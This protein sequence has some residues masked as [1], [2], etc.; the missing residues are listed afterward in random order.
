MSQPGYPG[1]VA[2]PAPSP[3]LSRTDLV[4]SVATLAVTAACGALAALLGV[5]LLAFLDDCPP[6]TCHVESAVTA[7]GAGLLVAF[8][9]GVIGLVA[10]VIQLVRR[11]PAWPFAVATLVLVLIAL[12]GGVVAYSAAVGA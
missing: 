9:I 5:F 1:Y 3:P 4:I 12:G 8:G 10:T 6:E 2:G 11:K 7:I